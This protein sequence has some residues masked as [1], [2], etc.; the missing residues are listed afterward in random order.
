MYDQIKTIIID[1]EPSNV[2]LL[3]SLLDKNFPNVHVIGTAANVA[4]GIAL[5]DRLQPDLLFLDISLPDGDGFDLLRGVKFRSFEV[6]FVTGHNSQAL[7]AFEFSAFDYL[8]K[9]IDCDELH[10][11]LLRYRNLKLR[12]TTSLRLEVLDENLRN[13]CK[14]LII[15]CSNML[16]V[17]PIDV[18]SYLEAIETSTNF[19]L[20]NQKNVVAVKPLN[21][22][23]KLLDEKSFAKAHSNCLVNLQ[24]VKRL[25]R[26][27]RDTVL[28]K[29]GEE[30]EVA[31]HYRNAFRQALKNF[32]AS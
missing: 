25:G 29:T 24:Y 30:I 28:L 1:D 10:T 32:S 15:P 18:I 22:Y 23:S 7:R 9:P 16:D 5:T 13:Q 21:Y 26:I 12:N 27:K 3:K 4:D 6:I 11:A 19:H 2:Q 8:L 31:V 14:K 20:S 17:V